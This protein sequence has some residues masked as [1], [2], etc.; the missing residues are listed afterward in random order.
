M[1][2]KCNAS[3]NGIARRQSTTLSKSWA[4][5]MVNW[6]S[7]SFMKAKWYAQTWDEF[8]LRSRTCCNR[9]SDI[10]TN[11][12]LLNA[13]SNWSATDTRIC[14]LITL[15]IFYS[16]LSRGFLL[17]DEIPFRSEFNTLSEWVIRNCA[18]LSFHLAAQYEK[19][20]SGLVGKFID[21]KTIAREP[22]YLHSFDFTQ[23]TSEE[24]KHQSVV[25]VR[26]S[27]RWSIDSNLIW[28]KGIMETQRMAQILNGQRK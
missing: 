27:W 15:E 28:L 20:A 19:A 2:R 13:H 16:L 6:F 25:E 18:V 12:V 23:T 26:R 21:T 17:S 10:Q 9:S 8:L 24:M 7:V 1:A 3:V 14:Y 11:W 22:I 5:L 4:L